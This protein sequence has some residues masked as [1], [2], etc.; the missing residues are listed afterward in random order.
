MK[1]RLRLGEDH[2]IHADLGGGS[3]EVSLVADSGVLWSGSYRMG[4]VRLLE[5]VA[6]SSDEPEKFRR[7]VETNL[8]KLHIPTSVP[9]KK[10]AGFIGTGGNIETIA[11]LLNPGRENRV[12]TVDIEE[13][14][15]LIERLSRMSFAERIQKLQLR[16][17]RADVI[18]PASLVFR[19]LV[20]LTAV[21]KII[22]PYAQLGEGVVFDLVSRS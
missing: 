18:L 19:R 12:H 6:G 21:K 16:E 11:T 9:Q 8:E 1:K 17:D 5:M 22:V 3:V 13:L 4:A 2:W 15:K 7:L 20:Y 10:L 14:D